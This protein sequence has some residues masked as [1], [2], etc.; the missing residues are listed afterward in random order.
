[1]KIQEIIN[2][3]KN[4]EVQNKSIL[5]K[6]INKLKQINNDNDYELLAECLILA[7]SENLD[8]SND[9]FKLCLDNAFL[10]SQKILDNELSW[11]SPYKPYIELG[12]FLIHKNYNNEKVKEIYK[13]AIKVAN[14]D[15]DTD[16]N[17][18]ENEIFSVIDFYGD[19]DNLKEF[20]RE[21][22]DGLRKKNKPDMGL[23]RKIFFKGYF[24]DYFEEFMSSNEL[25]E[26]VEK[27]LENEIDL[28]E[29]LLDGFFECEYEVERYFE[30]SRFVVGYRGGL[31]ILE[32]S[33][34]NIITR[35]NSRD[36]DIKRVKSHLELNR[37]SFRVEV[38]DSYIGDWIKYDL[39]KFVS[40][41]KSFD[42]SLLTFETIYEDEDQ[43]VR[44]LYDGHELEDYDEVKDARGKSTY[45]NITC[46]DENNNIFGLSNDPQELLNFI[47][48][49]K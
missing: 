11:E 29:Y 18:I 1:M 47:S 10:R 43:I 16:A 40:D 36:F 5:H 38:V 2:K 49:I 26:E 27:A 46:L 21:W 28:E 35:F 15:P 48:N 22:I 9:I 33:N 6:L 25:R 20:D 41:K 3:I 42:K 17:K 31:V 30:Q 19:Y 44:V 4:T 14:D 34:N 45:L 37:E 24:F 12:L 8:I 23:P 13:L 39:G 7:D 32:D